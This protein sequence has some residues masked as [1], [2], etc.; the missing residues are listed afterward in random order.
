MDLSDITFNLEKLKIS[1]LSKYH[2]ICQEKERLANI[3]CSQR[4]SNN[5]VTNEN[6]E[7]NVYPKATTKTTP[8][9]RLLLELEVQKKNALRRRIMAR[10]EK[11][12]EF[13]RQQEIAEK[14]FLSKF[15]QNILS[16]RLQEES[17]I[18]Q[19]LDEC[20]KKN[21]NAQAKLESIYQQ[22]RQSQEQLEADRQKQT[23]NLDRMKKAQQE[24]RLIYEQIVHMLKNMKLKK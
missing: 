5:I 15:Q 19:L 16:K 24:F 12:E 1:A 14:N 9:T 20:D 13:S 4:I 11:I 8:K 2:K 3:Q 17:H 10:Q 7:N 21:V 23:K 6:Q 22:H 18:S